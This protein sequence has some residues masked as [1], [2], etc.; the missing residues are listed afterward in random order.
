MKKLYNIIC[1]RGNGLFHIDAKLS[2]D[3]YKQITGFE[4]TI[5]LLTP[6]DLGNGALR[7]SALMIAAGAYAAEDFEMSFDTGIPRYVGKAGDIITYS[8]FSGAPMFFPG[9]V[10]VVG[11]DG[12]GFS[13]DCM[14]VKYEADSALFDDNN[15]I[16]TAYGI[17]GS[18]DVVDV[19]WIFGEIKRTPVTERGGKN[20]PLNVKTVRYD[21]IPTVKNGTKY[22]YVDIEVPEGEG[23]FPV[24]MWIHGGAWCAMDRKFCIISQTMKYLLSKGYAVVKAEY[25]LCDPADYENEGTFTGKT[26]YPQ[27]IYDLKAA[28]RF[29]RANAKKYNLSPYFIAAMGES[30]GGHLSMLLGTTNGNPDYE[31]LSMGNE[32]FSSDIQAMV[33]YYGPAD[34]TGIMGRFM[35]RS[36]FTEERGRAA[37]PYYQ[38]KAGAPP[39]FVTHGENDGAVD[40]EDSRKMERR[41][42]ELGVEVTACYYEDATH[43][44][45]GVYDSREAMEWVE[46][47]ITSHYEKFGKL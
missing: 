46:E 9:A 35:L 19:N 16:L 39:L 17:F 36:A 33:S 41:A 28:V 42:K 8:D 27:M 5:R 24:V 21:D 10:E 18:F 20:S 43:A 1:G 38:L 30:A 23:P 45:V 40:I 26:G 25:T 47:F 13:S 11:Q 22:N 15:S 14:T 4:L 37:S 32:G 3:N 44:N 29:I 12:T 7:I 6:G 31:D 34:L 2:N